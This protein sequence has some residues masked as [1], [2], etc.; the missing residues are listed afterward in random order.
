MKLKV[1]KPAQK[2]EVKAVTAK[3]PKV[4]AQKAE[5]VEKI[6]LIPVTAKELPALAKK[7]AGMAGYKD[8]Q[9][10]PT[11]DEKLGVVALLKPAPAI[12][13]SMNLHDAGAAG[14]DNDGMAKVISSNRRVKEAFGVITKLSS[15]KIGLTSDGQKALL[16]RAEWAMPSA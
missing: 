14:Y 1:A 7:A 12:L 3:K 8:F 9:N 16:L 2:A 5:K 10:V 4:I 13:Q 6:T 15:A 11:Y